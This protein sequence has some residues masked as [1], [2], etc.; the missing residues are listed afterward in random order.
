MHVVV[1]FDIACV[2]WAVQYLVPCKYTLEP[3][4]TDVAGAAP[5][6]NGVYLHAVFSLSCRSN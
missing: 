4:W 2:V 5:Q 1:T 6:L 3:L